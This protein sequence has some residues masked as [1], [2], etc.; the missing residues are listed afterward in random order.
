MVNV[1]VLDE[2]TSFLA[3]PHAGRWEI[4]CKGEAVWCPKLTVHSAGDQP[5]IALPMFPAVALSG[6]VVPPDREE[7]P[8]EITVQG[9]LYLHKAAQPL[10]SF[11]STIAT[12]EKGNFH[13]IVPTGMS[14]ESWWMRA[15]DRSAER[16]LR[17][18]CSPRLSLG[19]IRIIKV[20]SHSLP[21]MKVHILPLGDDTVSQRFSSGRRPTASGAHEPGPGAGGAG[22]LRGRPCPPNRPWERKPLWPILRWRCRRPDVRRHGRNTSSKSDIGDALWGALRGGRPLPLASA[23]AHKSLPE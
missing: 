9:W 18:I 10:A 22:D 19:L 20:N 3:L 17:R 14:A 1:P 6:R 2:R 13:L 4:T 7:L 15:G 21:W 12:E 5:E 11:I 8:A 16:R 23:A